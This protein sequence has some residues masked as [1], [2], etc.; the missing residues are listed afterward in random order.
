M[1]NI[2]PRNPIARRNRNVMKIPYIPCVFQD[3]IHRMG[4]LFDNCGIYDKQKTA[5]VD[6]PIVN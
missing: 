2:L 4:L 3:M 6:D 5:L 1:M